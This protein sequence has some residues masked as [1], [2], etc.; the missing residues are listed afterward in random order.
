MDKRA[1]GH[2]EQRNDYDQ[3]SLSGDDRDRKSRLR[4][5]RDR[6]SNLIRCCIPFATC[7]LHFEDVDING[8]SECQ[9]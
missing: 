9:V 6:K 1:G 8:T 4:I 7:R 3:S 5:N 2:G